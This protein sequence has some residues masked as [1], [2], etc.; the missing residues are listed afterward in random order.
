[1]QTILVKEKYLETLSALGNV[2]TE[3][4]H[5]LQ[6]YTVEQVA[7]KI[8]QLRQRAQGYEER[9]RLSYAAFVEQTSQDE[10]FVQALEATGHTMWEIDLAEWEF[11]QKGVEDWTRQ[12]HAILQV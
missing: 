6:R 12:L 4:E 11:C 2:E 3:V 9:Y 8:T 5:A 7:A 1:M 10:A